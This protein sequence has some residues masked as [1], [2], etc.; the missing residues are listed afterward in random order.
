MVVELLGRYN[1]STRVDFLKMNYLTVMGFFFVKL[2][3]FDV[4]L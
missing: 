4:I 1:N 3:C 2:G